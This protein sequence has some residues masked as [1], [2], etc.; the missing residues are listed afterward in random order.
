[1][2][3][4]GQTLMSLPA[5]PNANEA[6]TL[7]LVPLGHASFCSRSERV[8]GVPLKIRSATSQGLRSS[9]RSQRLTTYH[10]QKTT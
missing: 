2:E 1:M 6:A 7:V 9:Q 4:A 8:L 3:K 10:S 5:P